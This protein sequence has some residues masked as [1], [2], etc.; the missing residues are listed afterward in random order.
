MNLYLIPINTIIY[1]YRIKH[2][3]G[4]S[5]KE[6]EYITFFSDIEAFIDVDASHVITNSPNTGTWYYV[7]LQELEFGVM[8]E[9]LIKV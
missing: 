3:S 9:D 1:L 6:K 5:Y 2:V 7:K 8:K 4:Y